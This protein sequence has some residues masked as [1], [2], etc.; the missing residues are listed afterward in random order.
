MVQHVTLRRPLLLL[1]LAAMLP[2]VLLSAALGAFFLREQS[3]NIEEETLFKVRELATVIERDLVAQLDLLSTVAHGREFDGT[4][5]LDL[6]RDALERIR[7]RHPTWRALRVT[8]RE[9]ESVLDVPASIAGGRIIDVASH[10]EVIEHQRP[11]VGR[12]QRGPNR[13]PAF[14]L[15][16]PVIRNGEVKYVVSAVVTPDAIADLLMK[17]R[18]DPAWIGTVIDREGYV[19][20]RTAGPKSSGRSSRGARI[21]VHS[22]RK[23]CVACTIGRRRGSDIL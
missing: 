19:V 21:A 20:A 11:A 8:N 4:L 12:I 16:A 14:V 9:E 22:S 23:R 10:R 15:R 1:I 13:E 5:D 18:L 3:A 17:V 6:I 2:L 7:Q